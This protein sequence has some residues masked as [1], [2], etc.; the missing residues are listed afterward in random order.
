MGKTFFFGWEPALMVWL[1]SHLGS[2]GITLATIFSMFGEEMASI[3]VLGFGDWS[4]K[5]ELGKFIGRNACVAMVANPMIKN[6]FLRLR[7]YM[8]CPEV[9]CLKP[10][11]SSADIM[12]VA[13]QGYSFPSGHSSGSVANYTSVAA[14]LKKKWA[15]ALGIL[16]PLLVGLSRFC[17]G[18]HFPT[19]VL[20]G[21]ALGLCV[22]ML[23][24]FF[25]KKFEKRW[26]FYL[27]ILLLA[28][29]GWFY[30]K[31][32]DFYTSYGMMVGFFAGDLFEEKYVKFKNTKC[33]WKMILRVLGGGAV[34]FALN[35]LLKMPFS[36]SFLH[37][38]TFLSYL[39]RAIRYAVILFVDVAI[40]P[41]C[42]DRI[43]F[44]KKA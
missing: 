24:P 3:V 15:W 32:N 10:V 35:A 28:V 9:K 41:L 13:A 16:I 23:V 7:P 42:F 30:C 31:T 21:W 44:G 19:D 12:D 18:V 37:A 22:V 27:I 2:F 14:Y 4:G 34:Y 29:P 33:W 43:K 25:Q 17:V 36:S 6:V 26:V 1:Q 38:G 5:K 20:F 39:V 8:V 11:D 40:Y